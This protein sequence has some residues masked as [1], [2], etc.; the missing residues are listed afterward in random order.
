MKATL[1]VDFKIEL[2]HHDG[3]R[4]AIFQIVAWQVPKSGAYPEGIKYRAWLSESG[5]TVFGFDNHPPKGHHLH[6]GDTQIGYD[7]TGFTQ[8]QKDIE[9]LIIKEGFIY[10]I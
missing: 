6:L 8:L 2:E 3:I 5:K 7:Y 1:I 4:S 10:E 9:R